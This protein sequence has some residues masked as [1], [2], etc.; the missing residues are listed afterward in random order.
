MLERRRENGHFSI[1]FPGRESGTSGGLLIE[2]LDVPADDGYREDWHERPF[3]LPEFMLGL[4]VPDRIRAF[5]VPDDAMADENICEDDIVL[6]ELR[7][8]VRD[9]DRVVAVLNG[10]RSVLRKY[11]RSGAYIELHPADGEGGEI[12]RLMSDRIEIKGVFRGLLRP[13]L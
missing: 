3:A 13:V 7:Q 9:G 1:E 5:R 6:V 8:F 4:Q 12:I 2:W 10:E 11:Y